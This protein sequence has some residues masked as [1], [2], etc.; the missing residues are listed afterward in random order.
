MKAR[1]RV[2]DSLPLPF[3]GADSRVLDVPCRRNCSILKKLRFHHRVACVIDWCVAFDLNFARVDVKLQVGD[4]RLMASADLWVR[5]C[6]A[7]GLCALGVL[8]DLESRESAH[9]ADSLVCRLR[10]RATDRVVRVVVVGD[11]DRHGDRHGRRSLALEVHPRRRLYANDRRVLRHVRHFVRLG[12]ASR[13]LRDCDHG[14]HDDPAEVSEICT[15]KL[16]RRQCPCACECPSRF[17]ACVLHVV[18]HHEF[19]V[20]AD[21]WLSRSARG[22]ASLTRCARQIATAHQTVVSSPRRHSCRCCR[23]QVYGPLCLSA[24]QP[25]PIVSV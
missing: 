17:G 11:S 20:D 21:T 18:S 10:D 22:L 7:K 2:V 19:A 1:M 13:C 24:L 14:N 4:A 5:D 8:D 9:A 6:A 15:L 25:L 16:C 23:C 12:A 3:A